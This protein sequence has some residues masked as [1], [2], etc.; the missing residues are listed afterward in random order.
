[1][2]TQRG[3]DFQNRVAGWFAVSALLQQ[4]GLAELPNSP[5]ERLFFETSEP[6][7]D[8]ML[9]TKE[10][11]FIFIEVKHSLSSSPSDLKPVLEQFLRQWVLCDGSLSSAALPWRRPLEINRDRFLLVCSHDSPLTLRKHLAACLSRVSSMSAGDPLTA[12]AHNQQE[13][14]ALTK[15]LNELRNAWRAVR[16]KDASD[17]ELRR[18]LLVFRIKPLDVEAGHSEERLTVAA[19]ASVLSHPDQADSAWAAIRSMCGKAGADRLSMSVGQL[20]SALED[21]GIPLATLV[22][23]R[24]DIEKLKSVTK[25]PPMEFRRLLKGSVRTVMRVAQHTLPRIRG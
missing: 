1:M 8:L 14:Q 6:V 5:I 7:S 25:H 13:S 21:V 20:Q 11:G 9:A 3:I 4:S 16:D 22:S 18:F 2:A 19:L 23:F 12:L 10:D 15:F 17:Q 24:P